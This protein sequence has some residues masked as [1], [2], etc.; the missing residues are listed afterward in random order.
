MS[1]SSMLCS[2]CCTAHGMFSVMALHRVLCL[3]LLQKTASDDEKQ[4]GCQ[5]GVK[6]MHLLYCNMLA[7]YSL[8]VEKLHQC[9]SKLASHLLQ[10]HVKHREMRQLLVCT[11]LLQPWRQP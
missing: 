8:L 4:L 1:S 11:Q 3:Q 10:G 2:S 6:C 5:R 7:L 9:H